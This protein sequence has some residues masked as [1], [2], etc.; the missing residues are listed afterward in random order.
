MKK[1][2]FFSVIFFLCL[3]ANAQVDVL[4]YGI[5]LDVDNMISKHHI[6]YTDI[7]ALGLQDNNVVSFMLKNH[8]VDS[9]VDMNTNTILTYTYDNLHLDINLSYDIGDT[10]H[11][12]IYYNGGQVIERWG[13]IH[14]DA[15]LIYTIG[16]AFEDYPHSYARSWFVAKD[17]FDD[18]ATYSLNISVPNG[19]Q[20]RCTGM[21]DSVV[22]HGSFTTYHYSVSQNIAPYLVSM[23]IGNFNEYAPTIHSSTYDYDIPLTVHYLNSAIG[24]TIENMFANVPLAFDTLEKSFGRYAFNRVGYCVTPIGSMEHVDN[25]S[26]ASGALTGEIEGMSNIVHEMAHSWFGNNITCKTQRDMWLNE[27]WTSFTT[28]LSLSAIYGEKTTRDF[29]RNKHEE[30]LKDV[31]MNEGR[32][33]VA[34]PDS[35]QTYSSTVY[36]KGAEVAMSLKEYIGDELFYAAVR[37]MI[38]SF[39]FSNLTSEMLRDYLSLKTG[40]D[41]SSFFDCMVFSSSTPHYEITEKHFHGNNAD[42]TISQRAYPDVTKTISSSRIP[43]TFFDSEF[44][45]FKKY[46][47]FEG[48]QATLHITNLPFAPVN[49]MIDYDEEFMDLTTDYAQMIK[50]PDTTYQFPNTYF[51]LRTDNIEDSSLIR[52]TLHWIDAQEQQLPQGVNRLSSQHYWTIEGVNM[53][54]EK[55]HGEFR[56]EVASYSTAFDTTLAHEYTQ[57]DSL[58]LLYRRDKN[59]AW[60]H[61]P[62]SPIT[63]SKGFMKTKFLFEGEYIMAIGDVDEVGLNSVNPTDIRVYPN[64]TD[65]VCKVE[66]TKQTQALLYSIDG[67]LLK[68]YRFTEGIN[69]INLSEFKDKAFIIRFYNEKTTKYSSKILFKK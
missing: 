60:T 32:F 16:V 4:H 30:V 53:D 13:G 45:S 5:N 59:S 36:D 67:K 24:T 15:N 66:C 46:L 63:S 27:G 8:N 3:Y 47:V 48:D 21:L 41:L 12:R 25:I 51:R 11:I 22:N 40:K 26:L 33:S 20:A 9:I 18:K 7:K 50:T 49:A 6:G 54:N 43:V 65:N 62:C 64:P 38:D 69:T 31:V 14:Y 55:M 58:M 39:H 61:I 29:F 10:L 35:T 28:R 34:E 19:R 57:R 42:I 17:V 37:D 23:T 52:A 56:Y 2:S 68:K 1:L 44:N